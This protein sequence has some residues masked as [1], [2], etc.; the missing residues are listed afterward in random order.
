MQRL[1]PFLAL[2]F[3]G[4]ATT[5]AHSEFSTCKFNFGVSWEKHVQVHCDYY[6]GNCGDISELQLPSDIDFIATFIGWA[7]NGADK[8]APA[9]KAGK[10][11][12][13]LKDAKALGVTPMVYS[14]IIAEGAKTMMNLTDCNVGGGSGT[15]CQKGA[16]YIRDNE[17]TILAQYKAYAD[18]FASS[19][20]WGKTM[21]LIWALEPDF[22]QYT[23]GS[24]EGGG[25]SY[26]QAKTLL[27]KI[28]DVIKTSLPNAWLSMD[29]SPWKNQSEVIPGMVPLDKM[30]FMNTSGGVS[31]PE[32]NIKDITSWSS[33]W[34]LTK[35]GMI[36]DDGYGVGGN[37]T[38]PNSG[39]TN[40][41][42]L[43]SRIADGVVGLMEAVPGQ[44]WG[45]TITPL[46]SKLPNTKICGTIATS[47][48]SPASAVLTAQ[49]RP[50]LLQVA[51]PET[52]SARVL[53]VSASGEMTDLGL[54]EFGHEALSIPWSA[55]SNAK[56]FVVVRGS[57]WQATAP[58]LTTH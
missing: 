14:Y 6:R 29:I 24:Q 46:R 55:S 1:R 50:G 19:T 4:L 32:G 52:G 18:Y 9:P 48:R 22:I 39:W 34:N 23:D 30:M 11:G 12:A 20:R 28:A 5:A 31:L 41:N 13:F 36:A 42:N 38:S 57:D 54:H 51:A 15:L 21:P 35:L 47:P 56:G 53:I 33:V 8:I 10:E 25:L 43:K 58:L 17:A 16:K 27:G 45:S 44:N 7:Q 3:A 26:S 37:P 40:E 2:T 49:V